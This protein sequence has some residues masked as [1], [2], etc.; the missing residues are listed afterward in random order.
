MKAPVRHLNR[1]VMIAAA[2]GLLSLALGACGFTPMYAVQG[3]NSKL[4]SIEV[5]RPDG[6]T[7]FLLGQ[8]LDDE[9]ANKRDEPPKYRLALKLK[10]VRVPRGLRVNNVA[11]RYELQLTTNYTLVSLDTH[12]AVTAGVV[13]ITV[14]YDSADQ[15]YA[16]VAAQLDGQQRAA[17]QAAERI[18]LELA[19]FFDSP[20][21]TP[22]TAAASATTVNSFTD[23]LQ[24]SAVQTPRE[25]ALGSPTDQI[26]APSLFDRPAQPTQPAPDQ[27][28][29]E[30]IPPEQ[31]SPPA[32]IPGDTAPANP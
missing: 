16:G 12:A 11:S 15:P 3:V 8:A 2:I 31:T 32:P 1:S 23:R 14:T 26:A 28:Q 4:A 25:R 29:P 27:I 17:G 18:R 9:L 21:P 7:G 19:S 24:P 13:A 22:V 6:R 5:L 10:E 30:Q 20:P